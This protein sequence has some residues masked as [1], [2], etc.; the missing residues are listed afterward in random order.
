MASRYNG[1]AQLPVTSSPRA[2]LTNAECVATGSSR[3]AHP[4]DR[5][6][7]GEEIPTLTR[8]AS[9]C[10]P[11]QAAVGGAGVRPWRRITSASAVRSGG[12]PALAARTS[13]I[14]RKYAGPNTAGVAMARNVASTSPWF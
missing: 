12:P 5:G 3:I 11:G 6:G 1:R 8:K 2:T 14:S 7:F 4:S 10:E 9:G 13:P